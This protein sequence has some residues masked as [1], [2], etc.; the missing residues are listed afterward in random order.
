VP[1]PKLRVSSQRRT[2]HWDPNDN[3]D[4]QWLEWHQEALL[5][6]IKEGGKR[7][8]NMAKTTEDHQGPDE[9]PSIL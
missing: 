4:Y 8:M 2:P 5:G 6:D 3:R 9:S 7:A 1:K